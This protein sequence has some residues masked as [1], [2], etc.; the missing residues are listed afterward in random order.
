MRLLD[1]IARGLCSIG[2]GHVVITEPEDY[3]RGRR[4]GEV[5]HILRQAC[6]HNGIAEGNI[7]LVAS[8]LAGVELA[9]QRMGAEDLGLFL[10]LAQR[11]EII[12]YLN[13][14]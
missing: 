11:S 5:S 4:P 14:H 8:P 1:A 3:L 9:L 13:T 10:V 2:P 6:L 12:D 7:H